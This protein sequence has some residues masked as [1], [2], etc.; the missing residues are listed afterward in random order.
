MIAII[1]YRA[2]NLTSVERALQYLGHPCRITDSSEAIAKADRIIF[3]GVGAAGAAMQNLHELGLVEVI[4]DA[5]ASGKPF[6]GICLGYQ[7]LFE[8][9]D[10]DDTPCLGILAGKVVRFP[11]DLQEGDDPRS[12]KVPEM[13]WNRVAFGGQHPVWCDLPEGSEFYFVHSYYPEGVE[14]DCQA[15]TTYGMPYVCG[16]AQ[17]SLV[18]CQFH[19]EKSGR[20]GLKLLDNFCNWTSGNAQ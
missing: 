13:G 10:E 12:L 19:P 5:A 7:V 11:D 3:P 6:L 8:H 14:T 9:S 15:T 16:V 1:D 20:P 2:G 17:G 4:R 18:A